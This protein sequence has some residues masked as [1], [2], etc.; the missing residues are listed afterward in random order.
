MSS[1]LRNSNDH[2]PALQP[3][4]RRLSRI[5]TYLSVRYPKVRQL[6]AKRDVKR[7]FQWVWVKDEDV[8]EF[9]ASLP[10]NAVGVEGKVI[11][12]STSAWYSGGAEPPGSI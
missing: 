4:H 1:V 3:R 10:G 6:C 8:E 2:P 11:I 9:A 12:W 7:A 5:S